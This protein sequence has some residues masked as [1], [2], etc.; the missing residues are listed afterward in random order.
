[1][2]IDVPHEQL[3]R[4]ATFDTHE[5]VLYFIEERAGLEGFF[6]L[7]RTIHGAAVGGTRF[8]SYATKEEALNDALRLSRGM[9]YKCALASVPMGGGK[10]VIIKPR[11]KYFDRTTLLQAYAEILNSLGGSFYTGE[12]VGLDED[13]VQL[14]LRHCP[15]FIGKRKWVRRCILGRYVFGAP[16]RWSPRCHTL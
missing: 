8:W 2:L 13:D 7:H 4:F 1:M 15:Y 10:G 6:A 12:D 9:T 11:Q 16:V 14:M 3:E 5:R